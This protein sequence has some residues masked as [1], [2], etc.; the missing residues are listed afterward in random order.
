MI[1]LE[2]NAMTGISMKTMVAFKIAEHLWKI[3]E[4]VHWVVLV[5]IPIIVV[6]V[7]W[8]AIPLPIFANN[9]MVA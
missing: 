2:N 7:V 6:K 1:Y 8:F 3:A 5:E 9:V 4:M